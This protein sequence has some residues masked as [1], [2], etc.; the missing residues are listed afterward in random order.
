MTRMTMNG[1]DAARIA[2]DAALEAGYKGA[3]VTATNQNDDEDMF[4]V[5]LEDESGKQISVAIDG[6]SRRVV[7]LTT[8]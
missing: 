3:T 8:D 6:A 2:L 1:R 5:E 7:E 4:E